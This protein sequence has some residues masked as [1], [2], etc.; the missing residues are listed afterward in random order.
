[1]TF[2]LNDFLDIKKYSNL[3]GFSEISPDLIDAILNEGA[4]ITKEVLLPLNQIGDKEGCQFNDGEVKTPSGFK[5]AYKKFIEGGWSSLTCDKSYGGQGL[6]SVVGVAFTEMI[7]STNIAF[8]TYPGLTQGAYQAIFQVGNE[9]Q[10]KLFLPKLVSGVWTGTMNLTEPHCGTDLG[11]IKTKAEL[12]KDDTYNI[13]GTKIFISAGEHDLS[14]NIIHLVLARLPDAPSGIKGISL[15]A[16]PKFLINNDGSLGKRNNVTCGSIEQKMGIKASSTCVMNYDNAVGTLI[17]E[18]NKGMRAM[19]IMMNE[20]RLGV[21]L[22][23]LGLSEI[24]YQNAANYAKERIQG[25]SLDYDRYPEREAD[26]II[27]HPDVRRMLLEIRSFNEGARALSLWVALNV[28]ISHKHPDE[29]TR[30]DSK[31]LLSLMTPVLKAF[32]TDTGFETTNLALQCFGGHGYI[33]EN[34]MEQFVRDVR[35]AQLYEGTSGIQALD[36]VGRKLPDRMG[37]VLRQFFHPVES[38]L[39]ENMSSSELKEFTLPLAKSFARLQQATA[40][41]AEKGINDQKQAAAASADYLKMFGLVAL[42][43]IWAQMAKVCISKL[44]NSSSNS[45]FFETKIKVGEFYMSK[46]LPET[47]SLL[48]RITSGA[49]TL[50][51]LDEKEF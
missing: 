26:P 23:G 45:D 8:G 48:S 3:S 43:F 44:S 36:L 14:E 10:K 24:A 37:R 32:L 15:F 1:M 51:A 47:S 12:V 38:F 17:G 25:R 46:I 27:V 42:G 11:L 33:R 4:K 40:W 13:T 29:R 39:S 31:D 30:L 21:A 28:D 2:L 35:I 9:A 49:E 22:Q 34:G 19:F 6:P 41:I 50:M 16:V 7:V 5:E 18:P 20:A